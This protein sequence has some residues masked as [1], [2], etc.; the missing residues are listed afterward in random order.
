MRRLYTPV[1]D[2][3]LDPLRHSVAAARRR[4]AGAGAR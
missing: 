2:D 1:M 4:P 3:G